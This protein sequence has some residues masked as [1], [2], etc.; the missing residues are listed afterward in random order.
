MMI[1]PIVDYI[2]SLFFNSETAEPLGEAKEPASATTAV[3]EG[4]TNTADDQST[5]TTK[6]EDA[7]TDDVEIEVSEKEKELAKEGAFCEGAS[8]LP[9]EAAEGLTVTECIDA[10]VK[11]VGSPRLECV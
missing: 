6:T 5:A 1:L 10:I 7:V 11:M 3:E 9:A 4:P 2:D 8:L